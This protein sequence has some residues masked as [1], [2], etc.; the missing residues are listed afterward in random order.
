V[1]E[2]TVTWTCYGSRLPDGVNSNAGTGLLSDTASDPSLHEGTLHEGTF[3]W[4]VRD[5][6]LPLVADAT[7]G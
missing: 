5:L 6:P 2:V 4:T 1:S 7:S 3:V